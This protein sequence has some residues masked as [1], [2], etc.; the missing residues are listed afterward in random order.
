MP[1]FDQSF[2]FASNLLKIQSPKFWIPDPIPHYKEVGRKKLV[3]LLNI[4]YVSH[5]CQCNFKLLKFFLLLSTLL[6]SKKTFRFFFSY[7]PERP[8]FFPWLLSRPCSNTSNNIAESM[9]WSKLI[10]KHF[11][12]YLVF[13][14]QMLTYH[15]FALIYIFLIMQDEQEHRALYY[16]CISLQ[17]HWKL[18]CRSPTHS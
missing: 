6:S 4:F 18:C 1:F 3:N 15:F 2:K 17:P 11:F 16:Y 5:G 13:V 10:S 12:L 14:A 7:L 8:N 9:I